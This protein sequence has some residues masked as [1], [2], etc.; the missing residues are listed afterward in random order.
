MAV[1]T[2]GVPV[3]AGDAR[4]AKEAATKAVDA[5]C[6]VLVPA[7][8]VGT[9]GVP[10]RAGEASGA[11]VVKSVP[12]VLRQVKTPAEVIVQSPEIDWAP[13]FPINI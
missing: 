6:V 5:A 9:V 12:L 8:A 1:G 3:R 2:L 10:V 4:G 13:P 11:N 7:V